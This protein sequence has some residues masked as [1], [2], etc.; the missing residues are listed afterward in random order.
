[1]QEVTVQEVPYPQGHAEAEL[2]RISRQAQIFDPLTRDVLLQAGIEPGMRVLDIGC[3][4]G[5][6]TMLASELV[7]ESGEAVGIDLSPA[8]VGHARARARLRGLTNVSF[9]AGQPETVHFTGPFDAVIGRLVL[10]YC[11]DPVAALQAAVLH[12]REGGIVA[13]QEMDVKGLRTSPPSATF[14]ACVCTINEVLA[15]RGARSDQ[16]MRL[17]SLYKQ[18]GLPAPTMRIDSVISGGPDCAAFDLLQ[19]LAIVLEGEIR[20]LRFSKL[21]PANLETLASTM[22]AE[23]VASDAVVVY[24]SLVAAWSRNTHTSKLN[25]ERNQLWGS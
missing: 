15:R 5:D 19:E 9:V 12:V 17:Y 10:M 3:G 6:L 14:E 8:A 4:C 22:R 11:S 21:G 18:A 1:M 20:A 24:P 23:V 13:F 25:S 16:G 7:G 2:N